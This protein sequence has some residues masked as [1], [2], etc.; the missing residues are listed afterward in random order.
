Q[1]LAGAARL[2]PRIHPRRRCRAERYRAGR[3]LLRRQRPLRPHAAVV[4][5]LRPEPGQSADRQAAI[6]ALSGSTGDENALPRFGRAAVPGWLLTAGGPGLQQGERTS[7]PVRRIAMIL[8]AF[9]VAVLA[10]AVA[11][12]SS[13][14]T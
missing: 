1:R 11:S 3:C 12:S 6:A 7:R 9:I 4:R 8:A 10:T 14:G 5:R 2:L 13:P